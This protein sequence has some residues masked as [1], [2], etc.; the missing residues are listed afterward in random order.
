M[1]KRNGLVWKNLL[2][3]VE[4]GKTKSTQVKEAE[5]RGIWKLFQPFLVRSLRKEEEEEIAEIKRLL[6]A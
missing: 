2:E 3:S 5:F 1:P 4:D 6:E